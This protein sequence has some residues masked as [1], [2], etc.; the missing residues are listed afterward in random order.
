MIL[1]KLQLINP[2]TSEKF[3]E[4]VTVVCE[5]KLKEKKPKK[6]RF[7]APEAVVPVKKDEGKAALLTGI[8]AE[9][10]KGIDLIDNLMN[11]VNISSSD[12]SDLSQIDVKESENF[13]K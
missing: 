1:F 2:V 10:S 6:E 13:E 11:S 9:A 4:A 3:G 5:V 12:D 7:S 8:Q